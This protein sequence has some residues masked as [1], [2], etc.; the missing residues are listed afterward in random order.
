MATI[1]LVPST[2]SLS[3]ST[4]LSV[5]DAN[6]M[7]HNTDNT[8][9]ATVT[10]SRAST[11]SYYIY[12]K[13]FNFDDVDDDWIINSITIKVKGYESGVSTSTSYAPRLYNGTSSISTAS[14]ASQ[15]FSTSTRTITVPYTGD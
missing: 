14:A 2:Y 10:N 1:R 4:Y 6:N 3:N 11:T 15:T 5:S 8:T 13:G 12:V 7:Y 9:Y